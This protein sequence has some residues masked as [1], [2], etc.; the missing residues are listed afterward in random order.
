M[1]GKWRLFFSYPQRIFVWL[2][3]GRWS[4]L[5]IVINGVAIAFA[6]FWPEYHRHQDDVR[7]VAVLLQ[8]VGW[9]GVFWGALK[10]R[11]QFGLP[12]IWPT[13]LEWVKQMPVLFPRARRISVDA[14]GEAVTSA[15]A[16]VVVTKVQTDQPIDVQLMQINAAIN[17][18]RESNVGRDK[19]IRANYAALQAEI[20]EERKMRQGEVNDVRNTLTS[21]ATGGI[22]ITLA[23]AGCFLVGG[24]LGTLPYS[25]F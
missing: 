2:A 20:N 4:I 9:M 11:S 17:E 21:H 18:L 24:I 14:T 10:T 3:L 8:L 23:G 1:K 13:L 19:L 22:Q 15:G 12:G 6:W 16:G 25:L 5:A 7:V